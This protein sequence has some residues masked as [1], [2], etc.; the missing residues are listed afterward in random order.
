M[1]YWVVASFIVTRGLQRVT[2]IAVLHFFFLLA[3]CCS[4]HRS[5]LVTAKAHMQVGRFG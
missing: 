3:A 2:D 1:T 4:F 5:A